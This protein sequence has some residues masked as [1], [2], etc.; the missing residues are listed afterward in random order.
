MSLHTIHHL[1]ANHVPREQA[2]L[3]PLSLAGLILRRKPPETTCPQS[4]PPS[5]HS[6]AMYC[7]VLAGWC[8]SL[9]CCLLQC[10]RI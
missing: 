5:L 10:L 6:L 7:L 1:H 3:E 4:S 2:L 8:L 9:V